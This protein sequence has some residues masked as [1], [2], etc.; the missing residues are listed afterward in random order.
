MNVISRIE[1][2]NE[3]MVAK[4][5][6][7]EQ[8]QT[9][10]TEAI[11]SVPLAVPEDSLSIT[12]DASEFEEITANRKMTKNDEKKVK[13]EMKN[14]VESMIQPL[15]TYMKLLGLT[16]ATN[17]VRLQKPLLAY[18]ISVLICLNYHTVHKLLLLSYDGFTAQFAFAVANALFFARNKRPKLINVTEIIRERYVADAFHDAHLFIDCYIAF[19][20]QSVLMTCT[21]IYVLPSYILAYCLDKFTDDMYRVGIMLDDK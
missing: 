21:A 5:F 20:T 13:K 4:Y 12:F 14:L 6:K 10:N 19:M 1:K 16:N 8:I 18:N 9:S 17:N 15:I 11:A 3:T 7:N 2:S